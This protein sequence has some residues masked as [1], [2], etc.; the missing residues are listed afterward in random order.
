VWIGPNCSISPGTI[1]KDYVVIMPNTLVKSGIIESYSLVS[2]NG[3]IERDSAFVKSL[4]EN[5]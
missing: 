4:L 3:E 2:G 1:I 5:K